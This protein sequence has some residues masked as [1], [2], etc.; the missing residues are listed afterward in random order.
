MN[1]VYVCGT[2][3]QIYVS[4]LKTLQD[5]QANSKSMI[6]LNDHTP[7]IEK[8]IPVLKEHGFFDHHLFV[9]FRKIEDA[10]HKNNGLLERTIYRNRS[11]IES[12]EQG[13]EI[14]AYHDFFQESEFNLF[15]VWG[16]PSAYFVLKYSD[17]YSRIIEDG[18]RNYVMK[19]S[20]LKLLKRK[21][22]LRTYLGEGY[23]KAVKE[24]QVQYPEKLDPRIRHKGTTLALK[25]MQNNLSVQDNNRILG[26]FMKNHSV[27][28]SGKKNLLLITQPLSEDKYISEEY[29]IQL[30][31]EML[32]E[33][34]KDYVIHLKAHPRELT[35]YAKKLGRDFIEIPRAFPLE[36]LD[37]MQNITFDKGLTL[38]SSSLNNMA[39]IKNKTHLG[40]KHIKQFLPGQKLH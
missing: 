8:I 22:V 20:R 13:S 9:P 19:A 1:Q 15:Y 33:Y 3:F 36:M 23:D 34:A 12:V 18:T 5:N 26:V 6:I 38:F 10:M 17:N 30:Y 2:Y 31:S 25:T 40:K 21:Y 28:A 27:S 37:L 39:C 16:L 7:E 29:K 4:M 14:T 35:D 24:I 11:I 32:N